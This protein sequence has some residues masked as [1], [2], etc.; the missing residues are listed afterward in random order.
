MNRV[1]SKAFCTSEH[2]ATHIDAPYHFHK[3]G[4]TLDQIPLEDLINRPG[5]MIDIYDKVHKVVDGK[6]STI[7]NYVLTGEDVLESVRYQF[8]SLSYI[9]D[10]LFLLQFSQIA[11]FRWESKNGQIPPGSIVL[12]RTGWGS[13]WHNTTLFRGTENAPK[14]DVDADEVNI[15]DDKMDLNFPGFD[16]S[17]ARFLAVERQVIGVG[18]DTLSI[19]AGTSEVP[20]SLS[21]LSYYS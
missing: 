1:S 4:R 13:R 5:V 18:I 16:G 19:D 11:L 14:P 12:L 9:S 10:Y 8:F 7:S 6:L 15:M 20:R 3:S 2:T 21:F 17:A